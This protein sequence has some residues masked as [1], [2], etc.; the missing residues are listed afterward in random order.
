MVVCIVFMCAKLLQSCLTLCDPL[1]YSLP[2]PSVH[3]ILQARILEWVAIPFSRETSQPRDGTW[4]SHIAGRFFT[5]C[6]TREAPVVCITYVIFRYPI[7]VLKPCCLIWT[8]PS[9]WHD[10]AESEHRCRQCSAF[11]LS[12]SHHGHLG[13][14]FSRQREWL[15]LSPPHS[16]LPDLLNISPSSPTLRQSLIWPQTKGPSPFLI[17]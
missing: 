7:N 17:D 3:G 8:S 10:L 2:S 14:P 9:A 11:N 1:N 15:F 16:Y 6:D 5:L 13:P 4:V 12:L